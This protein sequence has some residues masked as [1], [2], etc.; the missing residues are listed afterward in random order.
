[1]KFTKANLIK[2][3]KHCG[4]CPR[5]LKRLRKTRN[6]KRLIA[7]ALKTEQDHMHDATQRDAAWLYCKMINSLRWNGDKIDDLPHWLHAN[8]ASV[9][10]AFSRVR[11]R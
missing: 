7:S 1:M 11:L 3:A 8:I 10:E 2:F 4:A 6:V 5:G 9:V